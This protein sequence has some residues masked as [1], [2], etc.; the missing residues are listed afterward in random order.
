MRLLLD[1]G[2]D[3]NVVNDAGATALALA[4]AGGHASVVQLLDTKRRRVDG[5]KKLSSHIWP[6][7]LNRGKPG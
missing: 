2:A 4:N 5:Q 6:F 3:K 1:A 7:F